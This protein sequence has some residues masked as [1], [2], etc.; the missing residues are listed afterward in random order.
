MQKLRADLTK[1]PKQDNKFLIVTVLVFSDLL[2]TCLSAITAFQFRFPQNSLD[3]DS[4][5]AIAQ[6]DYRGILLLI[7]FSWLFLFLLTGIYRFEHANLFVLNL[8]SVIKKSVYFF[9]FLGFISFILKA[10]FSRIVFG[11]MLVSGLVYLILGRL[12]TYFLI[13]KP[14]ILK[15]KVISNMMIVGR[16]MRE[17]Q[18]YSDWIIKNR[19]LGYAVVSRMECT[20]ISSAWL[21]EFERILKF[22]PIDEILLLPGMESDKNFSR[23]VHYCEDLGIKTNWIPLDSGNLGYWLIPKPQ[24]GIPFLAFS[25][26]KI[27]VAERILKRSFD[28]VFAVSALVLLS[29]VYFVIS[30]LILITSGRPVFYSQKRVGLNGKV[31]NFY[32]FRSMVKNADQLISSATNVHAKDHVIFKDKKDPRITPVGRILRKYSLDELPQFFNVL[33]NDMSVVGPRPALVH[34]VRKYDSMYERRLNAKPGVTGPWQISGRSDLDLQT[35]VALDLNY[36]VN[37]SFTRD[38]WIIIATIG[39]VF[40][41][42]GAY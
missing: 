16:I 3:T 29:P 38:L 42:R 2:A 39:A 27:S 41:G 25:Q 30:V 13:L 7:I 28:L 10:S 35:S 31:F 26:S 18:Q 33:I 19:L 6:F 1:Y 15:K 23:F 5:P 40:K 8:Q 4:K 17:C 11:V 34:E 21:D 36:M 24:V 37:W 14:L 20:A 22:T 9:F 32:K 12:I